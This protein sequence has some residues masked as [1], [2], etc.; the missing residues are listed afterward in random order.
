MGT[1]RL[2]LKENAGLRSHRPLLRSNDG[3]VAIATDGGQVAETLLQFPLLAQT[4][5]TN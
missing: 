2:L 5:E 3:C 4:G 1:A